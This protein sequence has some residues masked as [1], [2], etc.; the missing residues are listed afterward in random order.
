[1][2]V[3][4]STSIDKVPGYWGDFSKRNLAK[5][6][7]IGFVA[8]AAIG[9][10]A[11][12]IVPGVGNIVGAGVG[13]VVG[14]GLAVLN[15]VKEALDTDEFAKAP[16]GQE[17]LSFYDYNEAT[18]KFFVPALAKEIQEKKGQIKSTEYNSN[19]TA[20]I[21]EKTAGNID[22]VLADLRDKDLVL[23]NRVA[24]TVDNIR[25]LKPTD[26]QLMYVL[27]YVLGKE[28]DKRKVL[29]DWLAGTTMP[30]GYPGGVGNRS[31]GYLKSSLKDNVKNIRDLQKE[32][33]IKL[34]TDLTKLDKWNNGSVY[35]TRKQRTGDKKDL[36]LA[37]YI[38]SKFSITNKT[39]ID[40][41]ANSLWGP[42]TA[43][44]ALDEILGRDQSKIDQAINLIEKVSDL[45][46]AYNDEGRYAKDL[47]K[48]KA[49]LDI[50][51]PEIHQE[52]LSQTKD[53]DYKKRMDNNTPLTIPEAYKILEERQAKANTPPPPAAIPPGTVQP[54]EKAAKTPPET[55]KKTPRSLEDFGAI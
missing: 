17:W 11:G 31:I 55:V 19:S 54:E 33:I 49:D 18:A 24:F 37:E 1:M 14:A 45:T 30:S 48:D 16:L 42:H 47:E 21:A 41:F 15:E 28:A 3:S 27:G 4:G 9:G 8:G 20:E 12:T 51:I 39:Q 7:G 53:S 52:I 44:K 36:K 40:T 25:T 5:N 46:M 50:I 43:H 38:L 6:M 23:A 29:K 2:T 32:Q 26:T 10:T 35:D 22:A 34:I 13:A